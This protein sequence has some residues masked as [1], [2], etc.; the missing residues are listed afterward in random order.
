MQRI[1]LLS[2][3]V[4]SAACPAPPQTFF[5]GG[6]SGSGGD[7]PPPTP[8]SNLTTE[9]PLV[10]MF[11]DPNDPANTYLVE[12]DDGVM[13]LHALND[14]TLTTSLVTDFAAPGVRR[15]D[16]P[17]LFQCEPD[18]LTRQTTFALPITAGGAG[19]DEL[20]LSCRNQTD[21]LV[22]YPGESGELDLSVDIPSALER[23]TGFDLSLTVGRARLPTDLT[24]DRRL[25]ARRGGTRIVGLTTEP[26]DIRQTT[27]NAPVARRRDTIDVRFTGIVSLHPFA[28]ENPTLAP[29]QGEVVVVFDGGATPRLVPIQRNVQSDRQGDD[30]GD[31]WEETTQFGLRTLRLPPG[32]VAVDF[33]P[34]PVGNI[35]LMM[36]ERSVDP[37]EFIDLRIVVLADDG[38]FVYTFNYA[39]LMAQQGSGVLDLAALQAQTPTFFRAQFEDDTAFLPNPRTRNPTERLMFRADASSYTLVLPSHRVGWRWPKA[40]AG[41][42]VLPSSTQYLQFIDRSLPPWEDV[43]LSGSSVLVTL[44][45]GDRAFNTQ[46][47][48]FDFADTQPPA[49]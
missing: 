37:N 1:V 42:V 43:L 36:Q 48:R 27:P 26:E 31:V 12:K 5:P 20:W 47:R 2:V 4:L 23:V 34:E 13:R 15:G 17:S 19:S 3:V 29:P 45:S 18:N 9:F 25:F 32:T 14:T 39:W 30:G 16:N 38:G 22:V 11:A 46:V 28:D 24:L 6:G 40:Q 7:E 41:D 21:V 10:S 8:S 44:N 49:P 35:S 33:T